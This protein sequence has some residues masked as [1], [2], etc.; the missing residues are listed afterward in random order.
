M[1]GDYFCRQLCF[2]DQ[3]GTEDFLNRGEM[4]ILLTFSVMNEEPQA[5]LPRGWLDQMSHANLPRFAVFR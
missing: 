2:M 4:L 5:S 3:M 1:N